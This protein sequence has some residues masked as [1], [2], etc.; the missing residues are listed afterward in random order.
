MVG[1]N[2]CGKS[3]VFEGMLF[4][5]SS[6]NYLGDTGGKD[7]TY[8]SL[9]QTP[10]F[11]YENVSIEFDEGGFH[12]LRQRREQFGTENTLFSFRSPYRYNSN[13]KVTQARSTN[14]IR[15]NRYGASSSADI[16][17]KM[18]E[19][20]RR[21]NIEFNRYIK[22]NPSFVTYDLAK[23]KIIGDLNKSLKNCLDLEIVSIRDIED[24][25]G[26]LYFRKD[27]HVNEFDYNVLSSGE[28]EVVDILLDLY[29][30]QNDYTD[31]IFLIDEPELHINTSI[32]KKLLLEINNLIGAN[33]QI[34]ISTH[35]I[36]FLRALQ[37]ELKD[38]SQIIQFE[39][40]INWASSTQLLVPIKKSLSKWKEIF[41]TALDDLTGLV[42]PKRIIYCEGRD[43]PGLNGI[44]KGLDAKVFNNIY[45]EKYPDTLFISS[46][47]NTELDQRSEI[48][49]AILTKVFSNIEIL[50]FKDR[51]VS[52]GKH[53]TENDRQ[54]YLLNNPA[55]YRIMKRWEIENYLYDKEV[56]V[57]YC[58]KFGFNFNE[59][60]YDEHVLNI[61]DQNLKD[62]TGKIK[63]FCGITTSI[64]TEQF[65]I[66]LSECITENMKV[67]KE[68]EQCIFYR[69]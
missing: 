40:G 53:N 28:K 25:K 26:T 67:Y 21:I 12:E 49:L 34:W 37:Q 33:C 44:E 18:E 62:E 1:P 52:S 68:L 39:K 48:A 24:D 32:Q 23:Q 31:T 69:K 63:K 3:S 41:E 22:N 8:H 36:G 17:S 55:H 60:N 16:D 38:D 35:S 15:L 42:S 9:Y 11:N 4:L 61:Y 19:N 51:D 58:N 10:N 30:R 13:L 64:N 2:G 5:N 6:F 66:N 27:D 46:G 54:H 29:L 56:L 43:R 57:A 20:Y 47:G 50:V 59:T 65:K 45:G 14:E 7:H